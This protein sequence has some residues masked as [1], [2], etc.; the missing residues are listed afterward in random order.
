MNPVYVPPLFHFH[1]NLLS[2]NHVAYIVV[3]LMNVFLSLT[4]FMLPKPI[5]PIKDNYATVR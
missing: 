1:F 5:R 3:Q 2:L 4:S